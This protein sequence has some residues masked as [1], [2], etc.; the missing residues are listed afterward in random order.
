MICK[1]AILRSITAR[2]VLLAFL[3]QF[4]VTGGVL[5][6]VQEA[7][8]SAL[9][10]EQRHAVDELSN[11]LIDAWDRGGDKT[12]RQMIRTRLTVSNGTAAVILYAAADGTPIAGNLGAWPTVL[13]PHTPWTTIDLYR[14]GSERPEHMGIT[15]LRLPDGHRLLSGHVIESS[16]RL[17]RIN[18]EAIVAALVAAL[19]LTLLGALLMGRILS[20]R[21]EGIAITASAVSNGALE[22]RVPITGSD[23]AFDQLGQSINAMLERTEGLIS[24]L[25]MIT[26]GLAH[27]LR[28]PVTRMKALIERAAADTQD[29]QAL[30][31]LER[32]GSEADTLLR[33]LS[34]AL[35][36]SRAEAGIGRERFSAVELPEL[37][38]DLVEIYG[39]LA[40]D[41]GFT[42]TSRCPAPLAA[43][44]HREFISQALGN[45]IENALKYAQGASHITLTAHDNQ[46]G[47]IVIAV[48]DDG[49]GI[50]AERRSDALKRF[51]RLDPAR[52]LSGSGL[53]LSLVEAV[54]QLHHGHIQLSDNAPGLC[55]EMHINGSSHT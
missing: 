18:Q 24:Q 12:L 19:A 47:Q 25:R 4:L 33:M 7:S 29:S 40:E 9:V 22:A 8:Q 16:M 44:L 49:P 55:V 42:L 53:G 35:Q 51:G 27:D 10:A 20:Q 26:D 34:T 17:A 6:F 23:D 13:A 14:A 52:H 45:L 43:H 30:D 21:I 31:T 39:P 32:V 36:I 28:S 38:E 48:Y 54:A 1:F 41:G 11:E 37:L 3:V 46:N 15:T 2:F 5:L 50:P